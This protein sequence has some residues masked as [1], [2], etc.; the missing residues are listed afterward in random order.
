MRQTFGSE[1]T[2]KSNKTITDDIGLLFPPVFILCIQSHVLVLT[3]MGVLAPLTVETI[4]EIQAPTKMTAPNHS[5]CGDIDGGRSGS[6]VDDTS[7]SSSSVVGEAADD[8]NIIKLSAV[9]PPATTPK[10]LLFWTLLLNKAVANSVV[11]DRLLLLE[12]A[13]GRVL[14]L[15]VVSM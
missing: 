13:E 8:E 3:K 14:L 12:T 9:R 4:M 6:G 11:V 2:T 5:G 10:L 1:N 7:S 15:V